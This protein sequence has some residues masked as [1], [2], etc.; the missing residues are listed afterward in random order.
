MIK[1]NPFKLF[2][3][4]LGNKQ[5]P[6][7]KTLLLLLVDLQLIINVLFRWIISCRSFCI[8][9]QNQNQ[10][11]LLIQLNGKFRWNEAFF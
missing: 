11:Q 4:F 8:R 1:D 5:I 6:T 2:T 7:H 3:F 9:N 10:N